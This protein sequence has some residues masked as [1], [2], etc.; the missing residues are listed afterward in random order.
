MNGIVDENQLNFVEKYEIFKPLFL[1]IDA[2]ID[3]C[4]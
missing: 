2:I 1:K 4:F 3:N